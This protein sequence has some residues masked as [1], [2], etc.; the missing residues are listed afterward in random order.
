ML[1][2]YSWHYFTACP[3]SSSNATS[4]LGAHG[5]GQGVDEGAGPGGGTEG[6]LP[7]GGG[8]IAAVNAPVLNVP[9]FS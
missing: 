5:A 7:Q 8:G 1:I 9:R 6:G 2:I 3:F 4:R